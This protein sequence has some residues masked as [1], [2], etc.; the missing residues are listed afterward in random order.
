MTGC[1]NNGVATGTVS[2]STTGTTLNSTLSLLVA[3][4]GYAVVTG[5]AGGS[6]FTFMAGG[7]DGKSSATHY[8]EIE[9]FHH[10]TKSISSLKPDIY[11]RRAHMPAVMVG[12]YV[13]NFCYIL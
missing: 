11:P 1:G 4:Q 2:Y 12:E 6:T 8:G 10:G 3:R 9:I 7:N 13:H 5:T